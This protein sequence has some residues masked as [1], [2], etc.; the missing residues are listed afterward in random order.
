MIQALSSISYQSN[1]PIVENLQMI[2][3]YFVK[4]AYKLTCKNLFSI[5]K[6]SFSFSLICVSHYYKKH[7]HKSSNS[8]SHF[9]TLSSSAHLLENSLKLSGR[10]SP[11]SYHI[12]TYLAWP[13]TS[14]MLQNLALCDCAR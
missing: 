14:F 12:P 3:G 2:I 1:I 4:R 13:I 5:Q 7:F 8:I 6:I 10:S 11:I 9:S